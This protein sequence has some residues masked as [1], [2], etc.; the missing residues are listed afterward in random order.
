MKAKKKAENPL[1]PT[2]PDID[3]A[4]ASVDELKAVVDEMSLE[5]LIILKRYERPSSLWWSNIDVALH[6]IQRLQERRDERFGAGKSKRKRRAYLRL[7]NDITQNR[8]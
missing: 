8:T 5:Q 7:I 1:A 3:P 2:M 4:E 6:I